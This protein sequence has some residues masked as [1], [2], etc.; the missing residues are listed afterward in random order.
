MAQEGLFLRPPSAPEKA[1][2]WRGESPR[3]LRGQLPIPSD[4]DTR[5]CSATCPRPTGR[6]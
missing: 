3:Y 6:P 5:L 2:V 4:R 1:E